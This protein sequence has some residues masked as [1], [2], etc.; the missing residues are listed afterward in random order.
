MCPE[1]TGSHQSR[2]SGEG[3]SPDPVPRAYHSTWAPEELHPCMSGEV[4]VLKGGF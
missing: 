3:D 1:Q 2:A 4:E